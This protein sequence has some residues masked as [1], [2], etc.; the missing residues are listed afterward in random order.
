MICN[1]TITKHGLSDVKTAYTVDAAVFTVKASIGL[2]SVA[3]YGAET[4]ILT[5]IDVK[6]LKLK[7]KKRSKSKKT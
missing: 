2:T 3:F 4:W 7:F 6:T 1:N 5:S